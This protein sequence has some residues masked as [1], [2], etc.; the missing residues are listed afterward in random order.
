MVIKVHSRRII[1][2]GTVLKQE[3][4]NA[5]LITEKS[6]NDFK[7]APLQMAHYCHCCAGQG[8]INK[9]AITIRCLWS[10]YRHS[11]IKN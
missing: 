9:P 7:S 3:I 10:L 4:I 8:G 11:L 5:I 2:K 1:E 6:I